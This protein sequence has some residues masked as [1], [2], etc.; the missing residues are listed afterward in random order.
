M[1]NN[2]D[3]NHKENIF[4]EPCSCNYECGNFILFMKGD[5][6]H[7]RNAPKNEFIST[8]SL[9]LSD[10]FALSENLLERLD[11]ECDRME[12]DELFREEEN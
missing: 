11:I 4:I 5:R 3:L 8:A 6:T 1:T 2:P 9:S 12:L 10:M 7:F